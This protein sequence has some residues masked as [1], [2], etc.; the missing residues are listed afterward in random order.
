[1]YMFVVNY[2]DY[3]CVIF[4][5]SFH[6]FRVTSINTRVRQCLISAL[7]ESKKTDAH[8]WSKNKNNSDSLCVTYPRIDEREKK[9][10]PPNI[11]VY[12][13]I[14]SAVPFTRILMFANLRVQILS[15]SFILMNRV[16]WMA[17]Q[18]HAIQT[19]SKV[20]NRLIITTCRNS[21]DVSHFVYV[22]VIC[23]LIP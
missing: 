4:G 10:R 13:S 22:F 18:T 14:I 3:V 11:F 21:L 23:A 19:H 16:C 15:L 12:C 1:M 2:V 9:M 20:M 7:T 17:R 6:L 8:I 5:S